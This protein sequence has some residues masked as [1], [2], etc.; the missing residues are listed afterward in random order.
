MV[1]RSVLRR[2]TVTGCLALCAIFAMGWVQ[3]GSKVLVSGDPAPHVWG[4]ELDGET[5]TVRWDEHKVTIINFWAT[6]CHPCRAEMP[7]LQELHESYAEKGLAVIGLHVGTADADV[8][9]F[10]RETGVDYVVVR[11]KPR[12]M[13]AWGGGIS[14][15]PIT[16]LVDQSGT[17]QRRYVGFSPDQMEGVE[18][19]V[20]ALLEDRPLGPMRL[21]AAR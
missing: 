2:L 10:I 1:D 6:W 4:E 5:Y 8:A 7:A 12:I 19:D 11:A 17:I 15:L 20:Q 3:A 21:P 9:G 14:L 16:Y 13:A 18:E